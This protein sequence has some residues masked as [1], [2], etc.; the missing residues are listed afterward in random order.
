MIQLQRIP[1]YLL[2][3]FVWPYYGTLVRYTIEPLER[4]AAPQNDLIELGECVQDFARGKSAELKYIAF[5]VSF[6]LPSF[7][8]YLANQITANRRPLTPV[9][10]LRRF[11]GPISKVRLG[12]PRDYYTLRCFSPSALLSRALSTSC[13]STRC[14]HIAP[15]TS[16]MNPATRQNTT[17]IWLPGRSIWIV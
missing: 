6:T 5:A 8:L 12:P 7:L 3:I 11:R 15:R 2:Y 13:S 4:I 1:H 9:S 16:P 17:C 10:R 14:A